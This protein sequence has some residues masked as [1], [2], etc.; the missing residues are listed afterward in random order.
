VQRG[1][2]HISRRFR[3]G[4]WGRRKRPARAWYHR[5]SAS[6]AGVLSA[7]PAREAGPSSG[8]WKTM[9]YGLPKCQGALD[10][11]RSAANASSTQVTSMPKASSCR[12]RISRFIARSSAT[13]APHTLELGRQASGDRRVPRSKAR[14]V[15]ETRMWSRRPDGLRLQA[16]PPINSTSCL[17]IASPSPVPPKAASD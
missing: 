15:S 8:R 11:G 6:P 2:E 1:V 3:L 12:E 9:S 16:S 10:F 4:C 14:G 13:S 5:Q 7:P 17:Q